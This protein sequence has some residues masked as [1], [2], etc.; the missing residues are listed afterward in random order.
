ML[1]VFDILFIH[2]GAPHGWFYA[3]FTIITVFSH[4]FFSYCSLVIIIQSWHLKYHNER[5]QFHVQNVKLAKIALRP[6]AGNLV[7]G[8]LRK[9][10]SLMVCFFLVSYAC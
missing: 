4:N 9:L 1:T 8:L 7:N 3:G 2:S 10:I 6:G 5:L